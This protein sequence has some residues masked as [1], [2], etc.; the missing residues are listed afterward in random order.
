MPRQISEC[1]V[2]DLESPGMSTWEIRKLITE[3]RFE[4]RGKT[5]GNLKNSRYRTKVY[6]TTGKITETQIEKQN[7][8]VL[9][10]LQEYSSD[11]AIEILCNILMKIMNRGIRSLDINSDK[12]LECG[13]KLKRHTTQYKYLGMTIMQD[14]KDEV[15]I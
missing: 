6:V 4:F 11:Q 9:M 12:T 14:G 8:E 10:E 7:F 3:N 15:D 13:K 2:V 5:T 1:N